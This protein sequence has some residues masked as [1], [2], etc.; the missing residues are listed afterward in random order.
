[1]RYL[2]LIL[3]FAC[4]DGGSPAPDDIH[5][6]SASIDPPRPKKDT[7]KH[8][9][10][11]LMTLGLRLTS[12]SVMLDTFHVSKMDTVK[13]KYLTELQKKYDKINGQY[14]IDQSYDA[15]PK[16][17]GRLIDSTDH[18]NYNIERLKTMRWHGSVGG[19]P[20]KDIIRRFYRDTLKKY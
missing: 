19:S 9:I 8:D 13:I 2:L 18:P 15:H 14:P 16:R 12:E 3:L 7:T 10:D 5:I 6:D 20:A 1:M 4:N 17:H 11:T